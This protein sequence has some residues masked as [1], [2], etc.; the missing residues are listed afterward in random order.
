MQVKRRRKGLKRINTNLK[1]LVDNS[2]DEDQDA[3]N[4]KESKQGVFRVRGSEYI[5]D[6]KSLCLFPHTCATRKFI[7]SIIVSTWFDYFILACILANSIN[8]ALYDYSE[9]QDEE[10][11]TRF[12]TNDLLEV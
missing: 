5:Y 9:S 3:D 11:E 4:A 2:E 8:L 1:I 7:V 6:P 12:T 10:Y